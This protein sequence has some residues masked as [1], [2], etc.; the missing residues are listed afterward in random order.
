M[1]DKHKRIIKLEKERD[2]LDMMYGNPEYTEEEVLEQSRVV[3]KLVAEE[4]KRI[5]K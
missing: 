5:N 3:D 4:M 1:L 2:K